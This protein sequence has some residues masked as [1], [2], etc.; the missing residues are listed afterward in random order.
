MWV[1]MRCGDFNYMLHGV[2]DILISWRRTKM[3]L[4]RHKQLQCLSPYL[5]FHFVLLMLCITFLLTPRPSQEFELR[6]PLDWLIHHLRYHN[7]VIGALQSVNAVFRASVAL[8]QNLA[9]VFLIP[10]WS[11]K[12][13]RRSRR[14]SLKKWETPCNLWRAEPWI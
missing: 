6:Q 12:R 8:L 4:L 2:I 5:S 11:W 13:I 14:G 9:D 1:N 10:D 3:L 7:S